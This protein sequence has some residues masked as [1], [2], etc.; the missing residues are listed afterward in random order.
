MARLAHRLVVL[1]SL[2]A[3]GPVAA[4]PSELCL[5]AARQVS[6]ESGVPYDV[7]AAI[8]LTETGRSRQ[9]RTRPWPWTV[10]MEGKGEWF[11]TR[12]AARRYAVANYR[13]GARSF[14]IGCFQIN[15]KWH[16]RHFAS[17]E[18]MF[19][20][21]VNARYAAR[22]LAELRREFGD[23]TRAAGAF[24]SRSEKFASR[25]RARFTQLR[26]ALDAGADPAP[27]PLRLAAAEPDVT[28]PVTQYPLLAAGAKR[29]MGSLVPLGAGA[30]PLF[31]QG[32]FR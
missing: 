22:F 15:F 30:T 20:P 27:R 12:D 2:L 6:D 18:D 29:G 28:R 11:D 25:Y 7:L 13:R 17:I 14:D 8:S 26:A 31:E 10:N 32:T 24:H 3:P 5:A 19:D 21:L 9:G 16:G 4:D 1:L 23:W